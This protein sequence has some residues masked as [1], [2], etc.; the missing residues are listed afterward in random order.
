MPK[1]TQQRKQGPAP[2]QPATQPVKKYSSSNE[3]YSAKRLQGEKISTADLGSL[4]AAEAKAVC[5]ILLTEV[6]IE[7]APAIEMNVRAGKSGVGG[8]VLQ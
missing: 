6:V 7:K 3:I 1:R 8:Q 4:D 5:R 2:Q